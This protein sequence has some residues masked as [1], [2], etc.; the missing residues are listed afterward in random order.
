MTGETFKSA[1]V[2]NILQR[3]EISRQ[4]QAVEFEIIVRKLPFAGRFVANRRVNLFK[5]VKICLIF[6]IEHRNVFIF[7][8]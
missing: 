3:N 2:E 6:G 8:I 5:R 4:L 7:V 1:L